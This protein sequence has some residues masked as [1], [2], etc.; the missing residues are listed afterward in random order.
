ML[1][2][3]KEGGAKRKGRKKY[4]QMKDSCKNSSGTEGIAPSGRST[5]LLNGNSL[6]WARPG[7]LKELGPSV[8]ALKILNWLEILL[9]VNLY[10]SFKPRK[11]NKSMAV[12]KIKVP[13]FFPLPPV[14]LALFNLDEIVK[15][16]VIESSY[17]KNYSGAPKKTPRG[18][19]AS[20][21]PGMNYQI[22]LLDSNATLSIRIHHLFCGV[23]ELSGVIPI[24]PK[25][26]FSISPA[27]CWVSLLRFNGV[28]IWIYHH[29]WEDRKWE[30]I[31]NS[32]LHLLSVRIIFIR[33]QQRQ[34]EIGEWMRE[35]FS[36]HWHQSSRPG[37]GIMLSVLKPIPATK[38]M[39]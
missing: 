12:G 16:I 33:K 6:R 27:T 17:D 13:S 24:I 34:A 31:T 5:H 28:W 29:L 32:F 35:Y 15:W 14:P 10:L 3:Q 20:V 25:P 26:G 18:L 23:E 8:S 36:P 38:R 37:G 30:S 1:E 2:F 22:S 19:L 9:Y 39:F 4:I 11:K 21:V 7:S